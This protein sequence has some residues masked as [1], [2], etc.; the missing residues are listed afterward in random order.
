MKKAAYF[1]LGFLI[2]FILMALA[3][4]DSIILKNGKVIDSAFGFR[5]LA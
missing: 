2:P 4:A 5:I 1:L 3:H